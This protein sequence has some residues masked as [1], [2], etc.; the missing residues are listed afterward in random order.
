MSIFPCGICGNEDRDDDGL[1]T[2]DRDHLAD[3]SSQLR[4]SLD[5]QARA[6]ANVLARVRELE[7]A[8]RKIATQECIL[9]PLRQGGDCG[10]CLSCIARTALETGAK[11]EG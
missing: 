2:C 10:M 1:L 9:A 7:A 4:A 11:H 3:D 8:L 6:L 5:V